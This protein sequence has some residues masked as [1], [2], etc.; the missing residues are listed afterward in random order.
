MKE[1]VSLIPYF[2]ATFICNTFLNLCYAK[3][4]DH[5]FKINKNNLLI[6]TITSVVTMLNNTYVNYELKILLTM[7]ILCTSYKLIF[8]DNFKRTIISFVIIYSIMLLL[9]IIITSILSSIGLLQNGDTANFLTI[10]K[11]CLS[12]FIG[13]IEYVIFSV[14]IIRKGFKKL[15]KFFLQNMNAL[16]IAYLMFLTMSIL[17][18]FNIHNF[19][20]DNSI[21]LIVLLIIMFAILFAIIIKSKAHEEILKNSNQKLIDYN[22]RYGQFLDEYKIYKHNIKHKLAGIKT[23][24][25]TK[26]NA[27]IDDL[28]EEETH[29]TIRNNNLYNVPKGIKGIVAERLYNVNISVIVD[30]K[31]END[32]FIKLSPKEFN[33]VSEAIGICLD[34]AVEAS[35]ETEN[36]II[37]FDLNEDDEYI[38]IKTGNNFCNRIDIDE[39]G[40]KYYS[41]KNR[42]SGLGLFSIIQNKLIKE[43]ISIINDFYYIELKVKKHAEN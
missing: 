37:T 38:Y 5:S 1:L 26:I 12:I 34:N 33:A 41:T 23:F 27:L 7:I 29:F 10:I 39:L 9:E 36:P 17:G 35:L 14:K 18:I 28:L 24:G 11:I 43:K 42:G 25:N 31:I 21:Q 13:L 30:N 20:S 2:I 3:L 22:E 32:P 6:M 19:A 40:D 15:L 8:K 16:N 4:N